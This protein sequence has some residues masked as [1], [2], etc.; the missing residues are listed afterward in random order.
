[1]VKSVLGKFG[2]K[3]FV[4]N[5]VIEVVADAMMLLFGTDYRIL[6]QDHHF[7]IKTW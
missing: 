7:L 5:M 3:R 1:M 4:K 6:H 2:Q